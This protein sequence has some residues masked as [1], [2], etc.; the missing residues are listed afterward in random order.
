M[1]KTFRVK[2]KNNAS[3]MFVISNKQLLPG[4]SHIIV[5]TQSALNCL[6]AFIERGDLSIT[7]MDE[8]TP[9]REIDPDSPKT[10][11]EK[12]VVDFVKKLDSESVEPSLSGSAKLCEPA[13]EV[14]KT[15]KKRGRKPKVSK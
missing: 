1:K 14:K 9:M 13:S 8:P 10:E 15:V 4:E 6:S 3:R 5:T 2:F 7:I 11:D 12:E